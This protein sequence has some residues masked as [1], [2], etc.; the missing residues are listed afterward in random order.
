M[1]RTVSNAALGACL[2]GL[3]LAAWLIAAA[4]WAATGTLSLMAVV[5]AAMF[6]ALLLAWPF[7]QAKPEPGGQACRQCGGPVVAS[8]RFCIQCGAYPKPKPAQRSPTP[9]GV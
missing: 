9:Q 6:T 7:T 5:T 8:Y 3:A 2:L 1:P 4:G